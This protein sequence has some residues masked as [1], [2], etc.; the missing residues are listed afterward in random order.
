[1]P[2]PNEWRSARITPPLLQAVRRDG[3]TILWILVGQCLWRATPIATYQAMHDPG[4][5]LDQM[6]EP[7]QNLVLSKVAMMIHEAVR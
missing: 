4:V 3:V 1:V 7:E 5:A 6:E 2:A